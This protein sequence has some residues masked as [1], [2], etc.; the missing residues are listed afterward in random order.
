MARVVVR[1]VELSY[2]ITASGPTL[3][4]GHGLSSSRAH[5]DQVGLVDWTR[6]EEVCRVL[7][8]DARGHG[9]SGFTSDPSSYSWHALALDQIALADAVGVDRYV[10]GGASMGCGTALHAAVL[11]PER[12]EG[13]LLVIPPTAWES[14]QERVAIWDQVALII[15][16]QGVEAFLAAMEA[17]P[18]P[19]P[20]L[21]RH[22]WTL[23][24]ARTTRATDP[25]RLAGVF[26]GAATAD[27]PPRDQIRTI[28]APALILAWSGDAGHPVS[29]ALQ[30]AELLPN[31]ELAVAGTWDEMQTWTDRATQFVQSF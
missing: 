15:E 4:W 30:L 18:D 3:V 31:A 24:R 5:E 16:T 1:D 6:V 26:R 20:L 14:R 9:E 10:A 8:Y 27:L 17:M 12:I 2:G 19:D 23:A 25:A 11:A 29:T 28:S 21:G 13:L 22:E 7:R